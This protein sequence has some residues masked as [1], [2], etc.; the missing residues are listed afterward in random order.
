MSTKLGLGLFLGNGSPGGAAFDLESLAWDG[1]WWD[2]SA[3]PWVGEVGGNIAADGSDPSVG[4]LNGHGVATFNGTANKL[5]SVGDLGA[6]ATASAWTMAILFKPASIQTS[7]SPTQPYFDPCL[8]VNIDGIWGASCTDQGVRVWQYDG[9][10]KIDTAPGSPNAGAWN[11]LLAYRDATKI[12]SSLNG[13]AF[14]AGTACD[15]DWGGEPTTFLNQVGVRYTGVTDFYAGS[16]AMIALAKTNLSASADD[17]VSGV[18][19]RFGLS[20]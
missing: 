7:S 4:T 5:K 17:I 12:Y 19:S 15:A 16:I 8:W 10:Y 9:L 1:L 18:N 2:F 13:S 20:F 11:L 6:F 3:V 14:S